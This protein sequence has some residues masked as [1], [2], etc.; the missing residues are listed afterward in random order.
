MEE[1][2]LR[3]YAHLIAVTGANV[4]KGQPVLLT[5]SVDQHAFAEMVAEECYKAGASWVRVDWSDQK[6]TKLHYGYQSLELLSTVSAWREAQMQQMVDELPCRI[7]ISSEDPDGLRGLDM[8]KVQKSRQATYPTVRKYYDQIEN[9]HQWTIAAI[10][11]PEWARKVFPGISDEEAV[12]KLWQAIFDSCHITKD[13]D[14]I[15]AWKQHNERFRARCR[16]L[17]EQK[18]DSVTYKSSNGTD[19]R[20][21]LIPQGVWCG[22]GETTIG[23]VF[24]NPNMPTEEIF[25]SPMKGKAE[26]KLVSTKPLSYMGQIIENFSITFENGKAVR[27]EAEKGEELL[28]RMLTMDEGAAYLGELAL[29]P[30]QSPIC[31][32]G[33]LFYETLFDENA[34]CH[35]A[36]GRGF[37][38]CIEGYQSKSDEEC[39]AL[40]IN[41]SMVHTDFMVGADDLCITGWKN[42]VATPIFV[43]GEWAQNV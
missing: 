11:S 23:G 14:P 18:F 29:V 19:F 32:S 34:S 35:V 33:I 38:D 9:K 39:K 2:M 43:N 13:N 31:Q 41:D 36:V 27:W 21:E 3:K 42:G 25:T 1:A 28:T 26:G 4:Q 12:E 6:L 24:F 15:E 30:M 7:Y 37:N 40:G 8:E 22:G 17:N 20:A 5:A 10:P 16:W